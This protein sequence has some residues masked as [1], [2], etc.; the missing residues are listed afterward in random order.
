MRWEKC[1]GEVSPRMGAE[2]RRSES[3][4]LSRF[5]C[6]SSVRLCVCCGWLLRCTVE[7]GCMVEAGCTDGR[8][9]P[10]VATPLCAH[11]GECIEP[12]AGRA[13]PSEIPRACGEKGHAPKCRESPL[14]E[15]CAG[16]RRA[17]RRKAGRRESGRSR[18]KRADSAA[19]QSLPAGESSR[20]RTAALT[21]SGRA[22]PSQR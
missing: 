4:V 18:E 13:A 22:A 2:W 6:I 14:R 21:W 11:G 8:R 5:G 9:K 15:L 17:G 10:F 1:C 20:R 7:A 3:V 16:Q 12:E 19:G